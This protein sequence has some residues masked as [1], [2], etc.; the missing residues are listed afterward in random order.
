MVKTIK[1]SGKD[2]NMKSSAWT[3]FKYKN[4]FGTDFLQDIA[5]IEKTY[6]K[7]KDKSKEEELSMLGEFNS[8]VVILLQISYTMI[9][10]YDP[11]FKPFD[12]W[13][14]EI[15]T[16]LTGDKEEDAWIEEVLHLA[17]STFRR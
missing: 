2:Y 15:D 9:S 13:L 12:E 8:I 6:S 16:L 14:Q 3:P 1:I 7:I 11:Q 17:M 10:E 5:G 4:D